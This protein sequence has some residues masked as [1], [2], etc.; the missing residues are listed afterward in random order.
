M[1]RRG[2]ALDHIARKSRGEGTQE[3]LTLNAHIVHIRTDGKCRSHARDD[4][5]RSIAERVQQAADGEKRFFDDIAVKRKG[6]TAADQGEDAAN[7][8]GKQQRHQH[9]S[10][11]C[12]KI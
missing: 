2:N 7:A 6:I 1:Q 3:Y 5:R 4:D 10:S 12:E 11:R 9:V 8:E